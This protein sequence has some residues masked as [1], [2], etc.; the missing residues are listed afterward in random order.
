MQPGTLR[1]PQADAERPLRHSYAER[2]NDQISGE[3]EVA[4]ASK[5][6]PTGTAFRLEECGPCGSELARDWGDSVLR[7]A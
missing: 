4:I 1:V 7:L 6:A 5:L 2:G 3:V